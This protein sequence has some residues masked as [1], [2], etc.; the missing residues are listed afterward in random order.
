[1]HGAVKQMP[2][3]VQGGAYE[4]FRVSYPQYRRQVPDRV[5]TGRS[6][7]FSTSLVFSHGLNPLTTLQN[8]FASQF[9]SQFQRKKAN[10]VDQRSC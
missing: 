1:M 4:D 6:L 3:P 9:V 7:L 10:W 2:G 5:G 8:Q